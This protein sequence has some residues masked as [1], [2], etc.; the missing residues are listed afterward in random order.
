ML[1][2][3]ICSITLAWWRPDMVVHADCHDCVR[4]PGSGDLR[5]A[6]VR[7]RASASRQA[8]E[9]TMLAISQAQL[10]LNGLC[11]HV[12]TGTTL[13]MKCLVYLWNNWLFQ[14]CKP[15]IFSSPS[16]FPNW[17]RNIIFQWLNNTVKKSQSYFCL[18]CNTKHERAN[19]SASADD[20]NIKQAEEEHAQHSNN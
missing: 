9:R 10:W 2:W 5:R 12:H 17:V 19:G 7:T 6:P 15:P 8:W 1:N 18:M 16:T 20:C 11:S 3:K 14:Q 4:L 13:H